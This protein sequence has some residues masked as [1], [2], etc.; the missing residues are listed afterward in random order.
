M[1]RLPFTIA[2]S[3]WFLIPEHERSLGDAVSTLSSLKLHW[4]TLL[5]EL[6]AILIEHSARIVRFGYVPGRKT[7]AVLVRGTS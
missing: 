2:V 5:A 6:V 1:D 3:V 7:P 4:F